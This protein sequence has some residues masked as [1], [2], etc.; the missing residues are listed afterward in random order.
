METVPELKEVEKEV[1]KEEAVAMPCPETEPVSQEE[2]VVGQD[3]EMVAEP[4]QV[5]AQIQASQ[6][7]ELQD[8]TNTMDVDIASVDTAP[9]SSSPVSSPI[10]PPLTLDVVSI[11]TQVLPQVDLPDDALAPDAQAQV[12]TVD[13]MAVD[14]ESEHEPSSTALDNDPL[15]GFHHLQLEIKA[16]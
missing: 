2:P 16:V 4:A 12:A 14:K 3:T 8:I 6:L 11:N 13:N 1:E 10:P 5:E 15:P 7:G 9:R